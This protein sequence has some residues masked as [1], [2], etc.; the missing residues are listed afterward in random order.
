MR[1]SLART[2]RLPAADS[3][4]RKLHMHEYSL[5]RNLIRQLDTLREA[6]GDARIAIVRL[7]VGEFSGIEPGLLQTAFDDLTLATPI[8]GARLE[9]E[10]VPL[11]AVCQ[12]CGAEFAIPTTGPSRFRF[13][14][15]ACGGQRINLKRGEDLLLESVTMEESAA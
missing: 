9:I 10:R 3:S 14:C 8:Q 6:Q 4:A 7:R 12:N 5:V 11:E 13:V 2:I 15:A 1:T